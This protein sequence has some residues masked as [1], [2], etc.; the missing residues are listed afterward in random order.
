MI[1][2]LLMGPLLSLPTVLL[3]LLCA[4]PM[5]SFND[6]LMGGGTVRQFLLNH[7]AFPI[8]PHAQGDELVAWFQTASVLQEWLLSV[9]IALNINAAVLPI[10]Y[11]VS[12]LLIRLSSWSAKTDLALKRKALKN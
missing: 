6:R 11:G 2:W 3:A 4:M 12:A 5:L 8:L 7:I 9:L 10:L 1:T